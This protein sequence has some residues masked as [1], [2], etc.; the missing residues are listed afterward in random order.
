MVKC[1]FSMWPHFYKYQSIIENKIQFIFGFLCTELD[2]LPIEQ[3]K[4]Q[5]IY[6]I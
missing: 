4:D 1:S 3:N 5:D 2:M 6:F